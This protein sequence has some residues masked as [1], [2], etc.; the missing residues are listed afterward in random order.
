MP[1][2]ERFPYRTYFRN[3]ADGIVFLHSFSAGITRYDQSYFFQDYRRQYG[4]TYLE[5]FD[6]IAA[7]GRRRMRDILRY[8]RSS[9][10][11]D[12]PLR[13][14]DLGCAY[15]P[16]LLAASREGCRVTGCEINAEAVRYVRE[17]LGLDVVQGDLVALKQE[18][19]SDVF[20]IV[21]MWYV[22]EHIQQL[23]VVLN[24]VAGLLRPGGVLAFS[25]PHGEGIS[26]RRS[27]RTFLDR[28]PADHYTVW[29][30]PAARRLLRGY[31]FR[32]LHVRVTG[33]HPERF[34]GPPP[35]VLRPFAGIASRLLRLGDTFEVIA[36]RL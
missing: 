17:V 21:T 10:R 4:R 11:K 33:H 5:D 27:R 18:N 8:G 30:I 1:A 2:V 13:L 36:E 32:V 19:F 20:D 6:S 22:I 15:G 23:Q 29:N 14:L 12:T 3:T 24:T 25:T 9:F 26:A 7:T 34:P 28:S 31:G 16:F 35:T